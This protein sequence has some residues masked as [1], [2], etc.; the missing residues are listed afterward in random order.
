MKETNVLE[1]LPNNTEKSIRKYLLIL[2]EI[3]ER[4][5]NIRNV[6]KEIYELELYS[7]EFDE[8]LIMFTKFVVANFINEKPECIDNFKLSSKEVVNLLINSDIN[9]EEEIIIETKLWAALSEVIFNVISAI[10]EVTLVIYSCHM[11]KKG[12]ERQVFSW[13][14]IIWKK[15][16]GRMHVYMSQFKDKPNKE[17]YDKNFE[18]LFKDTTI[19]YYGE[20]KGRTLFK[21]EKIYFSIEVESMCEIS[22]L[23]T[24]GDNKTIKQIANKKDNENKMGDDNFELD[25]WAKPIPRI[26]FRKVLDIGLYSHSLFSTLLSFS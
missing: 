10:L 3:S 17:N 24:F 22:L 26:R 19:E 18:I 12:I 21:E 8:S 23:S 15:G 6:L 11:D 14:R 9:N 5:N 25:D 4:H 20:S 16:F 2:H 7:K 13:L 1:W